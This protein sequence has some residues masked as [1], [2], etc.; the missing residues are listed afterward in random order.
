MAAEVLL[1]WVAVHSSVIRETRSSTRWSIGSTGFRYAGWSPAGACWPEATPIET[2]NKVQ[3]VVPDAVQQVKHGILQVLAQIK[4]VGHP[5]MGIIEP[6]LREYTHLGDAASQ[7]DGRIYSPKPGLYDVEGN[8]SGIPDDRWAFTT[9]SAILRYGDA[10]SLA[11]AARVLKGW[12]DALAKECLDTAVKLYDDEHGHPTP[13]QAGAFEGQGGA[14][15]TLRRQLHTGDASG[16]QHLL[17]AV[18]GDVFQTQSLWKQP[19]G[20]HIHSRRRDSR[21]HHNQ[22]GL[23]G[24][25]RRFRVRGRIRHQR[26]GQ[27]GC[28]GQRGR[29][30]REAAV[31]LFGR[32]RKAMVSPT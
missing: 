12:D 6:N 13:S 18:G 25:Y 19:R 28:G 30:A 17:R 4:A 31:R 11:A 7:T 32:T 21:L 10:A 22:A 5:F 8:L 9:K 14:P 1:N 29:R 16:I 2:A 20:Q 26:G 15:D 3:R 27:L 24:M 23:S